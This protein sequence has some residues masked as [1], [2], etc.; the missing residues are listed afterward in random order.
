MR[1]TVRNL[2]LL[3]KFIYSPSRT[4]TKYFDDA[5]RF[6]HLLAKDSKTYLTYDDFEGLLQVI[7]ILFY[8]NQ[9][10]AV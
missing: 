6:F 3:N 4:T 7:F 5:S 9:H 2:T 10:Q 1:N 8:E